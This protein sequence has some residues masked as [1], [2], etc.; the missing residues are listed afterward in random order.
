MKYCTVKSTFGE[1]TIVWQ[2][3]DDK[4]T[5]ILLP[6]QQGFLKRSRFRN[7]VICKSPPRVVV[8]LCRK[9]ERLLMGT[10]VE[11]D[12]GTLDWSATGRFQECVLRME[13]RIPRGRVSTYGRIAVR[14]GH[15]RAAR[16]VGTA[17]ARNPFP[18]VIP[19]HRAVRNDR[20][21]GGYAGGL[22]MKRRLLELEGV[23]FDASG[24]VAT[25]TFW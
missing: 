18:L 6:T 19:C 11:F 14:L 2:S 13:S 17:L 15:P 24:R 21:L 16:A 8:D 12:L 7:A 4:V 9:M 3:P 1:L 25:A 22:K 10:A 5:R 20:S 23:K